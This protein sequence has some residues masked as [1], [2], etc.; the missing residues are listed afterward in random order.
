MALV[1]LTRK[2]PRLGFASLPTAN[3]PAFAD[4]ENRMNRFMDRMWN[5]PFTAEVPETIGWY[6]PMDIAETD[7][8]IILTAELA[9][10][11]RKDIDISVEDGMLIVKGEKMEEKEK[12]EPEKKFYLFERTFGAFQRTFTLPPTVDASKITAEF[13]KGLLKVHMLKSAEIKP[14]GRKIDIKTM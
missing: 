1:R 13:E 4:V 12:D 11:D 14:T 8:E 2:Q 10:L 7:K 5:E 9:G 3:L 6:P